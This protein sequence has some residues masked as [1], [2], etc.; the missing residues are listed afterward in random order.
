[1]PKLLSLTF[2]L[3]TNL[4]KLLQ[5]PQLYL[6]KHQFAG[7]PHTHHDNFSWSKARLMH[8]IFPIRYKIMNSQKKKAGPQMQH[9]F[10]WSKRGNTAHRKWN[11]DHRFRPPALN[12]LG[13]SKNVEISLYVYIFQFVSD[14]TRYNLAQERGE[15]KSHPN[16]SDV[17]QCSPLFMS[18]STEGQ[19]H[20][21]GSIIPPWSKVAKEAKLRSTGINISIDR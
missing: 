14:T 8:E 2:L 5:F 16:V 21:S 12:G 3:Y 11:K 17:S 6:T 10:L 20:Y 9:A 19:V 15:Q 13:Q 7:Y 18:T 4:E 1:M